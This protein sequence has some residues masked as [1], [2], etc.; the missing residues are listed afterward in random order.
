MKAFKLLLAAVAMTFAMGANAQF[1]NGKFTAEIKGGVYT[2]GSTGA[3]AI[4]AGYQKAITESDGFNLAWDVVTIDF[5]DTFKNAGDYWQIGIKTGLRGFTP[6]FWGDNWRG[7]ANYAGGYSYIKAG[8]QSAYGMVA[9]VGLQFKEKV[10]VG[11]A[12]Q[13]ETAGKTKIHFAYDFFLS[14]DIVQYRKVW[15]NAL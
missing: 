2:P 4:A 10:S 7:Y 9:G 11:Y 14:Q 5:T 3:W 8:K 12:F 6:T 15:M 1:F 13:Y